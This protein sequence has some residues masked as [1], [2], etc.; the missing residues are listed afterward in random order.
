MTEWLTSKP[1]TQW[2]AGLKQGDETAA[3]ELWH[4]CFG[5]LKQFA[6]ARLKGTPR[7]MADEEDLALSVFKSLCLGA[8]VG[9]F[10]EL[11]D[12]SDLWALLFRMTRRKAVDY[13]RHERRQRRGGGRV[14]GDSVFDEEKN[15]EGF[16][17][18]PATPDLPRVFT[19][20]DEMLEDLGDSTLETIV[21]LRM[22]GRATAEIAELLET[23]P[24]T[25]QRKL[26]LVLARWEI[27]ETGE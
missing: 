12:R 24:R 2:I 3:A 13:R 16:D 5:R 1:V 14:R 15:P 25:I 22:E 4:Y 19:V 10:S 26:K 21:V 23:T 17:G 11:K 6:C 27:A 9:R 20:L 7:G 8:R 18:L